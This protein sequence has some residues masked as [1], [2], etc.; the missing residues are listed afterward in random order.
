[1]LTRNTDSFPQCS[2][3]KQVRSYVLTEFFL[4]ISND[5]SVWCTA[6]TL[7]VISAA[8]AVCHD[9]WGGTEREPSKEVMQPRGASLWHPQELSI[10]VLP[11]DHISLGFR[12][13]IFTTQRKTVFWCL[14]MGLPWWLKWQK[15]KKKY[16][17]KE[18]DPFSN[19]GSGRS[20]A[21]GHGNTL[22]YS[23]LENP[24]NRGVWQA[25]VY[26]VAKSR[27]Q[28]SDFH[29]QAHFSLS[30]CSLKDAKSGS[31]QVNMLVPHKHCES[32]E[33]W[34]CPGFYPSFLAQEPYRQGGPCNVSFK[35]SIW[36]F[37]KCLFMLFIWTKRDAR[38]WTEPELLSPPV[39]APPPPVTSLV[40]VD[41]DIY[42]KPWDIALHFPSG[43]QSLIFF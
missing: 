34:T 20:P 43:F 29:F 23:C 9:V 38:W 5:N 35:G 41:Y 37:W 8:T 25:M 36:P 18:G 30:T 31:M 7:G 15:K 10:P 26:G 27:T 1:M 19:P 14:N 12:F 33:M 24:M 22:Q 32:G 2:R 11:G 17:C 13:R 39:K 42:F 28:L 40:W 6:S 21:G 4:K 16:A 3:L